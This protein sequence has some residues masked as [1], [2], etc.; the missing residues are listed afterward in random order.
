MEGRDQKDDG[1]RLKERVNFNR[2][3]FSVAFDVT[4]SIII[5][6]KLTSVFL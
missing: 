3:E 6:I 2:F 4:L 1:R 5:I